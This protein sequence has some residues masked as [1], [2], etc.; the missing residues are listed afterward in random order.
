MRT[1]CELEHG[2]SACGRVS[3]G[4]GQECGYGEERNGGGGRV[5]M[6]V[7]ASKPPPPS[8]RTIASHQHAEIL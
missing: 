2:L 4:A 7:C 5:F 1:P 8:S 6:C 3:V